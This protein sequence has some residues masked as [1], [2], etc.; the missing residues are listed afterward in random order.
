MIRNFLAGAL[1]GVAVAGVGLGVLSQVAPLPGVQAGADLVAN[2]DAAP[3]KP[4]VPKPDTVATAVPKVAPVVLPKTDAVPANPAPQ[5]PLDAPAKP[6]P[7]TDDVA[8]PALPADSP[9]SGLAK[10]T[11]PALP[12]SN[13]GDDQLALGDATMAPTAKTTPPTV[14]TA[15]L[16]LETPNAEAV[17]LPA[18]N[19]ADPV[20]GAAKPGGV[21]VAP[22]T[23]AVPNAAEAAPSKPEALLDPALQINANPAPATITPD[24]PSPEPAALPQIAPDLSTTDSP[25]DA[26]DGAAPDPAADAK[27]EVSV[28][29]PVAPPEPAPSLIAKDQPSTFAP[30]AAVT[31]S[32]KG[33]TTGRL[34][35]IGDQAAE[36]SAAAAPVE[37]P[38]LQQFAQDFDNPSAKPLF[39]I[40]LR[41]TG[42]ADVD[43]ATLAALPFPVSFVIDPLAPNAA[44]AA[45]IYR[46]AG[47]EVIMLASGIPAGAQASDLEQ[48]FQSL[49]AALPQA[50]AVMDLAKDGFQDNRALASLVVPIIKSQ[51][52]GLITFNRGLNA[53]DQVA[54]REDVPSATIFRQLDAEGEDLPLIRRYLD[55]AAF[56]AAQEG[57]V[58]VL[59]DTKP[60]TI[61]ALMEWTVEGRASSVTLAPV[62]AVLSVD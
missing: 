36:A 26:A 9:S 55:R 24:Q 5:Q 7:S 41:D 22:Q 40:V 57:R 53:A 32:A 52:R 31:E 58:V 45:A 14:P 44:A 17:E 18:L 47:Q 13:D 34:P 25:P 28:R 1:W 8:G 30:G 46:A 59:G 2:T 21:P 29:R 50:V 11:A 39:A 19:A 4:L 27:P 43:R 23:D 10:T 33:V 51:G 60:E 16:V 56:K 48:S 15:P 3:V 49:D 37:L 20:P 12:D 54:R 35:R 61:A 42:E 6:S 62:T 38:A